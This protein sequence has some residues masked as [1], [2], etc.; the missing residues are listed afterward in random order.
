[1]IVLFIFLLSVLPL[2]LADEERGASVNKREVLQGAGK[3]RIVS[4]YKTLK[5]RHLETRE[6]FQKQRT[7]VEDL[8]EKVKNCDYDCERPRVELR[9]GIN[10]HLLKFAGVISSSLE[11][12]SNRVENVEGLTEANKEVI[13]A[14]ISELEDETSTLEEKIAEFNQETSKEEIRE[15]IQELKEIAKKARNLQKRIVLVLV[16]EKLGQLVEKHETFRERMEERISNLEDVDQTKLNEILTEFNVK[17]EALRET[18][19]NSETIWNDTDS[20]ENFGSVVSRVR[21]L[22]NKARKDLQETKQ[23]LREFVS[24]Y[25][26][27]KEE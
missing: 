4:A 23:L 16:N 24:T 3:E 13:L 1:M 10:R 9:R 20:E 21:E 2:A 26:E 12:L 6:E 7:K 5:A 25:K 27:A 11:K 8:R 18:Y 22:Q 15:T 14:K 19:L 17:L